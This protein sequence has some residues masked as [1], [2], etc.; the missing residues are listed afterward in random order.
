M[1]ALLAIVSFFTSPV[2]RFVG[3]G[4]AIIAV[5][6]GI[7]L[8]GEHHGA[9]RIQAKWDQAVEASIERGEAARRDAERDTPA[10]G[11]SNDRFNRD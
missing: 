5:V 2:G 10:D 3:Y 4:L 11:M 7:W 6:G 9:K 1:T 8:H